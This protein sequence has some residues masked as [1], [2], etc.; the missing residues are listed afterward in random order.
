MWFGQKYKVCLLHRLLQVLSEY[1]DIYYNEGPTVIFFELIKES[2]EH[3]YSKLDS[4]SQCRVPD[5]G[6]QLLDKVLVRVA[7]S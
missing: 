2:Y 3:H 6:A 5:V 4:S 7:D 1:R